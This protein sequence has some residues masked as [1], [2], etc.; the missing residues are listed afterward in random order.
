MGFDLT[1]ERI[2]DTYQQILQ[3]SGSTMVDGTG[4]AVTVDVTAVSAS[5]AVTASFALNGGGG[6]WDEITGKPA[7]LVSGSSQ[8]SY[9]GISDV[10]SGIVSG[11]AQLPQIA[12]NQSDIT[13]LTAQTS[14]YLT[15]VPSGTVSSSAQTLANVDGGTIT[16]LSASNL[17]FDAT[18]GDGEIKGGFQ[19]TIDGFEINKTNNIVGA[20]AISTGDIVLDTT[21]T[22]GRVRADNTDSP[23]GL[24]L[25]SDASNTGRITIS[26]TLINTNQPLNVGGAITASNALISGDLIVN[27]TASFA[28][29]Q[30]ITGS[31]KIIGDA[32]II[33]NNNTPAE[34]YAGVKV[35]DSGSTNNSA[36]FE[37]DG[38]TND[39]FY[40]Y[41]DD[42]GATEEFGVVMF[43]P[44]YNTRGSHVYPANNTILKGTGDHH[45]EDSNITDDGSKVSVSTPLTASSFNVDSGDISFITQSIAIGND[46]NSGDQDVSI[47]VNVDSN[48]GYSI[49]IGS[50]LTNNGTGGNVLLGRSIT[51][52]GDYSIGIG[53]GATPG[54]AG[55]V[56]IGQ[57]AN[58]AGNSVAIGQGATMGSSYGFAGGYNAKANNDA[59]IAVGGDI[60]VSSNQ[61]IGIGTDVTIDG[62]S[63]GAVS[64]GQNADIATSTRAVAIGQGSGATGANNG[65]AIGSGSKVTSANEINIGNKFKYDGTST[66]TLDASLIKVAD[67]ASATG[68]LVDNVHPAIASGSTAIKHIVTIDQTA[69]D[70]IS[71]SGAVSDDTFYIISDAGDDVYPGNLQVS[72][73]IY[74]PTFAGTI[75]SSTSSISFDN[76]NFATLNCASST[77]LANPTNLQGGTTY[78]LIV[79]NGANISGYGTVWKFAGGT[80]PTLSANTDVI[81]AVSDGTSLY[82]AALADFS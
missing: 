50:N 1:N 7:G 81:T 48:N 10:P 82:A 72:G 52:T 3:I 54:A 31:A 44:G 47:G 11:A 57:N 64:L 78:T 20:S 24:V 62:S 49:A 75:A 30:S 53:E 60:N 61:A 56:A 33:L 70:T 74:S 2:Q 77:F 42:G 35:Y 6:E 4:S 65:I 17:H 67:S 29:L 15:S 28:Y 5:Y 55:A 76:G 45:I 69:Y 12:T 8:V 51:T 68:S 80:E 37:F 59:S 25:S 41:T 9:T 43:G 32:Y 16:T 58:S 36:S 66:I 18:I 63:Q 14:S 39:W 19:S 23:S 38:Q 46:V 27:G 22:Y 26:D 79:T 71:G 73:Q 40:E 13:S 21:S 34:R